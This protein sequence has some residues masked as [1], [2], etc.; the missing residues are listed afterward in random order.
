MSKPPIQLALT[1]LLLTT[2]LGGSLAQ[3]PS[4]EVVAPAD[5][6][7][8]ERIALGKARTTLHRTLANL[9]IKTDLTIGAW[10]SRNAALDRAFRAWTRSQSWV[11]GPRIY[12]DGSCDVDVRV[13]PEE[14]AKQLMELR[15]KLDP[16]ALAEAPT[17]AEIDAA[18][19]GWA[20]TWATG[21]A[22][23]PEAGKAGTADGWEDISAEGVQLARLAA[24]ADAAYAMLDEAAKLKVTPARRVSEFLKASVEV[25]D[26]V[27]AALQTSVQFKTELG[28]DQISVA[29]GSIG[30]TDLI[31]ILTQ[32]HQQFYKGS[33][34]QAADFREMSINNPPADIR[35]TGLAPPPEKYRIRP[36]YELIELD[37]PDWTTR[38]LSATGRYEPQDGDDF[39]AAMRIELARWDGM[40]QLRRLVE[41]L[42]LQGDITVEKFLGY[43]TSLKPDVA[44]F[45]SG[46][47]IINRPQI[48]ADDGV[49]VRV[50]IALPRL[51]KILRR[52]VSIMEVEPAEAASRPALKSSEIEN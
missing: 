18:A 20:I 51:W 22:E 4:A 8:L 23:I 38:T 12:A 40:D 50:E 1:L 39:P 19:R 16:A 24:Q 5:R 42:V 31:R 2:P 15:Q 43:R 33:E 49:E 14:I 41:S 36:E 10:V 47:R 52:G 45:L 30:V 28:P 46:A 21:T 29:Q 11:G 9:P 32:V 6:S 44:L 37:R 25:R 13:L 48:R 34:F 3:Q 35:V 17:A 26:A 7:S 27:A